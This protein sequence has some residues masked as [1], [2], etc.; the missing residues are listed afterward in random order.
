MAGSDI[1]KRALAEAFKELLRNAPFDKVRVGSICERCGLS[2][3]SFYYHFDDK[4]DLMNWIYD[5]EL[6]EAAHGAGKD[7]PWQKLLMMCRCLDRD[8]PFYRQALLVRGKNSFSEHFH[9][10]IRDSVEY[11]L[12]TSLPPAADREGR[13]FDFSVL[14]YS[15][16]IAAAVRRWIV[17]ER[18]ETP[19]ELVAFI[20]WSL[21]VAVVA[22][23]RL[24]SPTVPRKEQ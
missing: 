13:P 3:K 12:D 9:R 18:D 5:T 16:A 4:Y 2:R 17:E 6:A 10:L 14:F 20:G 19:E 1:T 11:A 21:G 23:D 8:R 22:A 24:D 15:D 7:R